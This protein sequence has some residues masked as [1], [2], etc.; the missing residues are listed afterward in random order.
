VALSKGSLGTENT[1]FFVGLHRELD[2]GHNI[3]NAMMSC[4]VDNANRSETTVLS[5]RSCTGGQRAAMFC[6]TTTE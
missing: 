4:V 5:Y 3:C 1:I 2:F 6:V